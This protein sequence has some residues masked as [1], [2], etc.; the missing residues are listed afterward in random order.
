[1]ISHEYR[2]TKTKWQQVLLWDF[3]VPILLISGLAFYMDKRFA[4]FALQ[5]LV[6]LP[7]LGV[8]IYKSQFY[9]H[10]VHWHYLYFWTALFLFSFAISFRT[11]RIPG[12][13]RFLIRWWQGLLHLKFAKEKTWAKFPP[14]FDPK[15]PDIA[16]E[17][18][19]LEK[20]YRNSTVLGY[21]KR[22]LS[23]IEKDQREGLETESPA[24]Y[25][26]IVLTEEQR[27][28]HIQVVGGSGSGKSASVIA[29]ML[30]NDIAKNNIST[31]T[32][33]PKADKYLLKTFAEGYRRR[34]GQKPPVAV[35]SF[36]LKE[37]LSYDPLLFGDADTLTKKIMGSSEINH[38]FYKSVQ[39][40]WLMSFFRVM[41][42]EPL[43]V[44]RIMLRHLHHY[45][46]RPTD[47][48]DEIRPLCRSVNNVRRLDML[49]AVKPEFL[50]GVA[51]HVS[52]FVEDES[53]AHV[54]DNPNGRQLNV[55]EIIRQ[56]G[57]IF[58]DVNCST[59][60]PQGRAL[61]RMILME[62]Q[63]LSGA[64]QEGEES[65]KR[66]IQAYLDEFPSFVYTGF[67]DLIDK[68]RS[69]RIGLLLSHQSLGNLK[70]ENLSRSFKDEL[71][72]NCHTKFFVA[73]MDETA[74]WASRQMGTREIV[75][76]SITIGHAAGK[77]DTKARENQTLSLKTEYQPYV[78]PSDFN[79]AKGQG[80]AALE[81]SEGKLIKGAISL[82]FVSKK[83]LCSDEEL[84]SFLKD[85]QEGHPLRPRNGSLIDNCIEPGE[86]DDVEKDIPISPRE[87]RVG[88][89]FSSPIGHPGDAASGT[90]SL[91]PGNRYGDN[92]PDEEGN[93]EDDLGRTSNY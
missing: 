23:D 25:F 76:K 78:D 6:D 92:D 91:L 11:A 42:T 59:K 57:H 70:R 75:K 74:E 79:L 55:Q 27:Y 13:G 26:P 18:A 41:K 71:V 3:I 35:L 30:L 44:D 48:L 77:T 62:L 52:L 49:A 69:A 51:S 33:D 61:G 2:E 20:I 66:G 82:G 89:E 60:G 56:G 83:D 1:M 73:I 68:C 36:S 46:T 50:A 47:L 90:D 86:S 72:D 81:N 12:P 37:S 7:V 85:W 40:T 88:S 38:P 19:A 22:F 54:F 43:L 63:L 5:A 65:A 17:I 45:L 32:I 15:Q 80:Y 31:V 39:E 58:L 4:R 14:K 28:R 16:R 53:L 9:S 64:R 87:M 34:Q 10:Y 24:D 93:D 67:I 29:P 84:R 8:P 21:F